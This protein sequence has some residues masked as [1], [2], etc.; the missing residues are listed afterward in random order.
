MEVVKVMIIKFGNIFP[1]RT[2]LCQC[3]HVCLIAAKSDFTPSVFCKS[4]KLIKLLSSNINL[5]GAAV[6]YF[7]EKC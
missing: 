5:E 2:I 6:I 4:I 7:T 1:L 3:C